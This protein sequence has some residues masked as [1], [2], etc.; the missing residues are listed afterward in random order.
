MKEVDYMTTLKA[1]GSTPIQKLAGAVAG[2]IRNE[3]E[4]TISLVGS[5]A[6]NQA[7]K[8]CIIARRF[9]NIDKNPSDIY[10]Q[11]EF[12]IQNFAEPSDEKAEVTTIA[13][14][15]YKIDYD[16]ER[17]VSTDGIYDSK[18]YQNQNTNEEK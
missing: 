11:P 3:G 18:I 1:S 15:I 13:L 6:L 9:L 17:A 14:H 8:A 5:S 2:T 7:V 16:P 4:V 10:I 12:V